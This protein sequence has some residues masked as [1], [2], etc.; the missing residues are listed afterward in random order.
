MEFRTRFRNAERRYEGHKVDKGH[1]VIASYVKDDTYNALIYFGRIK[2]VAIYRGESTYHE[3]GGDEQELTFPP[4]NPFNEIW[5]ETNMNTLRYGIRYTNDK[6][7]SQV[8]YGSSSA[9]V[10]TPTFLANFEAA[11]GEIGSQSMWL[12]DG[13]LIDTSNYPAYG[14]CYEKASDHYTAK[15]TVE[16]DAETG[17]YRLAVTIDID[18]YVS[19]TSSKLSDGR[20]QLH[21]GSKFVLSGY[22]PRSKLCVQYSEDGLY[23][24]LY[25]NPL[26]ISNGDLYKVANEHSW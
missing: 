25:N 9:F 19:A 2:C 8:L 10:N 24:S 11:Y 21:Q 22:S 6:N 7:Y 13:Q 5:N 16:S 23:G 4:L 14:I 18:V 20:Y 15:R 17:Y 3:R 12:E 1:Y 26:N